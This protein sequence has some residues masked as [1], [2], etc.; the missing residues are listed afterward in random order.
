MDAPGRQKNSILHLSERQPGF[1]PRLHLQSV[2]QPTDRR[3]GGHFRD[4]HHRGQ[5]AHGDH[6]Q[7]QEKNAADSF[8]I[9]HQPVDPSRN[10]HERDQQ[11]DEALPRGRHGRLPNLRRGQ[12]PP[13]QPQLPRHQGEGGE[14]RGA[15][16]AVLVS[17]LY[18]RDMQPI[19]IKYYHKG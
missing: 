9:G 16:E 14:G 4:H 19:L 8:K 17:E 18:G 3:A 13:H 15:G 11:P 12:Q 6:P 2:D 5:P 7:F 10:V 1:L